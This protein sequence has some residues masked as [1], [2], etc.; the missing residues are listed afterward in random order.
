MTDLLQRLLTRLDEPLAS[1]TTLD[2]YYAGTQP[3]AF[4]AP[5]AKIALGTRLGRMSSNIPRLAVTALTER[6]RVIG[7]TGTADDAGLWADWLGADLDQTSGVAHREALTLGA[8]YVIVWAG[9]DGGP[10]V[11]VESAKQVAVLR[12]PATRQVLAAVK[13]WEDTKATHAVLLERDTI[14]SFL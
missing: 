13:R 9:A 3:L 11:T 1:F 4:L 5:E 2:A 10:Q 6:L 12:D 8:A 7:F 14:K